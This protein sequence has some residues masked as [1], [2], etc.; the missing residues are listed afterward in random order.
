MRLLLREVYKRECSLLHTFLFDVLP[1]ISGEYIRWEYGGTCP[2]VA[3]RR[4][5]FCSSSLFCAFSLSSGGNYRTGLART[6]H[7]REKNTRGMQ[8]EGAYKNVHQLECARLIVC[9]F[10]E[11]ARGNLASYSRCKRITKVAGSHLDTN[12]QVSATT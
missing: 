2:I 8:H 7:V 3:S 5:L 6:M 11:R 10:V 1:G 9:R 4:L 12:A